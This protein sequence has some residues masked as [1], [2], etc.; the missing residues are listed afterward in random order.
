MVLRLRQDAPDWSDAKCLG[1]PPLPEDDVWFDNSD[2]GY[3][4]LTAEGLDFCNG[5]V[6]DR[7]CPIREK[8]LLFALV[9]NERLG[10]WGGTSEADRRAIRKMWPWR[11]GNVPRPEWKWYP[12]GVIASRLPPKERAALDSDEDE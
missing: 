2:D 5:V 1:D 12:P 6:D 10:V 8:C 7:V 4:D 9:N 3:E 11:G